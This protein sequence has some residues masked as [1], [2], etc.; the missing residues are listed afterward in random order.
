MKRK[1]KG[2][3]FKWKSHVKNCIRFLF[4]GKMYYSSIKAQVQCNNWMIRG[5][6]ATFYVLNPSLFEGGDSN[7]VGGLIIAVV[8]QSTVA[9][10]L[11]VTVYYSK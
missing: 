10:H 5:K 8:N 7:T 11:N 9:L 2:V 4:Y 6:T 3:T 1:H